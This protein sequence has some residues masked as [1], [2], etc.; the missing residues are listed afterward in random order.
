MCLFVQTDIQSFLSELQPIA[1]SCTVSFKGIIPIAKMLKMYQMF[2]LHHT[3]ISQN[4]YF[5]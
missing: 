4:A 3:E 2:K 5:F 1:H